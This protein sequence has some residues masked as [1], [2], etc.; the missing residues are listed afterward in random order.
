MTN[1]QKLE[2]LKANPPQQQHKQLTPNQQKL[3]QLKANPSQQQ[4]KQLTPNQQ[5]LEQLKQQ[6][7][8]SS[9]PN[10]SLSTPSTPSPS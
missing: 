8:R 10:Q 2:Q 6:S 3:E 1:Q 9:S 4:Q 5:K 7:P